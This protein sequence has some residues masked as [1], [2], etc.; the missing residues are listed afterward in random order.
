[1]VPL[2]GIKLWWQGVIMLGHSNLI[3][4]TEAVAR[5]W[6]SQTDEGKGDMRYWLLSGP[7]KLPYIGRERH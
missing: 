4:T 3:R 1:M 6:A 2:A 5:M 7:G